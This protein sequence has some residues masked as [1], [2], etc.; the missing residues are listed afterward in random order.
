MIR[1][2]LITV[3]GRAVEDELYLSIISFTY[4]LWIKLGPLAW[5]LAARFQISGC[6]IS[7]F[8]IQ[9][10]RFLDPRFQIS[11]SK[12]S[13]FWIRYFRFLDPIPQLW[14]QL[15]PSSTMLDPSLNAGMFLRHMKDKYSQRVVSNILIK[16][17]IL[18]ISCRIRDAFLS[19]T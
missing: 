14:L 19:K 16:L 1:F 8:W 6:K 9:D 12:I 18:I 11:G 4:F 13:Y 7:D 15:A 17:F 3:G 10:F 5:F 2:F